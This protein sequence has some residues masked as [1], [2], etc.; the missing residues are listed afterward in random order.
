MMRIFM[1]KRLSPLPIIIK[2]GS[3]LCNSDR[4]PLT[5]LSPGKLTYLVHS[6]TFKKVLNMLKKVVLF[7]LLPVEF[8]SHA[9][10]SK[11]QFENYIPEIFSLGWSFSSRIWVSYVSHHNQSPYND[12]D[13]DDDDDDDLLPTRRCEPSTRRTPSSPDSELPS[14]NIGNVYHHHHHH[15]HHHH[16]HH[17]MIIQ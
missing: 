16:N 4:R 14:L 2:Q 5:C 1:I 9:E 11:P 3:P 6:P 8:L 15:H 10:V 13:D 17:N 7:G 12:F